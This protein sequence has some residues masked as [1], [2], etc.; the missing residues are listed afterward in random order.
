MHVLDALNKNIVAFTSS[1]RINQSWLNKV[2][3]SALNTYLLISTG[4]LVETVK[5]Y[6][7]WYSYFL[8]LSALPPDFNPFQNFNSKFWKFFLDLRVQ[9][10]QKYLT[11]KFMKHKDIESIIYSDR[12]NTTK[13]KHGYVNISLYIYQKKFKKKRIFIS[14]QRSISYLYSFNLLSKILSL[15]HFLFIYFFC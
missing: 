14:V 4:Q 9:L 12:L 6:L 3:V 7:L 8:R 5:I 11:Q 2:F 1:K 15:Y 13:K 10:F